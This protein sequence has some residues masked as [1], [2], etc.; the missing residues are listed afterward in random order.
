MQI[1]TIRSSIPELEALVNEIN[2]RLDQI[3]REFNS[4][5]SSESEQ[6]RVQFVE[7]TSC[8]TVYKYISGKFVRLGTMTLAN[9]PNGS[10]FEDESDGILKYKNHSGV[11]TNI[12]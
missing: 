11:L 10:F 4:I 2:N 5:N 9:V 12:T 3:T 8:T 1:P 6:N 7:D